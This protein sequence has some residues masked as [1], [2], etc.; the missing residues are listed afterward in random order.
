M[1]A[2]L[3]VADIQTL[4]K[5]FET[6]EKKLTKS[7][8]HFKSLYYAFD[9][10]ITELK[11]NT[12]K[13]I[14]FDDITIGNCYNLTKI[15]INA[16]AGTDSVTK[17]FRLSSNTKLSLTDN[18]IFEVISKFINLESLYLENNN[19]TEIP[20]NAFQNIVGYQDKL[21]IVSIGGRSIK[22]IGSRPFY[23]LRGLGKLSFFDTSIEYIPDYALE[24]KEESDQQLMLSFDGLFLNSYHP[25]SLTRFKRPVYIEG[26]FTKENYL[27]EHTF[28]SFLNANP[29]NRIDMFSVRLD[30][31]NCKNF[32][33]RKHPDLWERI[34]RLQCSNKKQINDPDNFKNCT[35]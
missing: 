8:K 25:D 27:D 32:W 31:N 35:L 13:D 21:N 6:L 20:S 7:E 18:L 26:V 15:H 11:E 33:I 14:T 2:T 10:S 1:I 17:N 34:V 9:K 3:D 16:F 12:F 4:Y 24:F 30:C 29:Q 5:L 19:F 22:K 23:L 28:K